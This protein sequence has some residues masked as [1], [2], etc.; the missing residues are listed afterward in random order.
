MELITL[1]VEE[2]RSRIKNRQ[3]YQSQ[4]NTPVTP[5]QKN[6]GGPQIKSIFKLLFAL[7]NCS[8]LL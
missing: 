1:S 5:V 2:I 4:E 6:P 8:G 3:N 7:N